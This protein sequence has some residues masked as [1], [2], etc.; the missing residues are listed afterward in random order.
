VNMP[1]QFLSA[2]PYIATIVVLV[3]IS[4][5]RRLTLINT[6]ASLGKGYVPDR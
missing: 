6:P 4:R 5:N 1:S 3:I 2:L